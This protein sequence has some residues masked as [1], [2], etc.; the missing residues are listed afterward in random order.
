MC[1]YTYED[2]DNV[3]C[4]YHVNV[5]LLRSYINGYSNTITCAIGVGD[6]CKKLWKTLSHS[7]LFERICAGPI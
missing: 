3:H 6:M 4:E 1:Y 2:Y 7:R 5:C